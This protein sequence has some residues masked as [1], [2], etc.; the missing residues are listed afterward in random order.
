M[1]I[2]QKPF[3]PTRLEEEREQGADFVTIR[4]NKEERADL[5]QYKQDNGIIK[6][7]SSYKD[8]LIIAGNVTHGRNMT[9]KNSTSVKKKTG[10]LDK[11]LE[12]G[13]LL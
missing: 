2:K 1:P 10:Y 13:G 12:N 9:P 3:T 6:D 4:L 8:A 5:E 7:S 11:I